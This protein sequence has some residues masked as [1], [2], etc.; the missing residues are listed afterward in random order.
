[1]DLGF[2]LDGV[3]LNTAKYKAQLAFELYGVKVLDV[4]NFNRVNAVGNILTGEQY[5]KITQVAWKASK[6]EIEPMPGAIEYTHQLKNDGH[7]SVIITSRE[8]EYLEAGRALLDFYGI[9]IETRG[10]GNGKSKAVAAAGLHAYVD[11]SLVKLRHLVGVVPHRFLFSHRYN[12]HLDTTWIAR[13]VSGWADFYN[14]IRTL[15]A[16]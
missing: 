3:W 13:R 14:E 7:S 8:G 9:T 5:T 16:P 1:M 10:V 12:Q 4:D 11:D 2:D 15:G 6:G